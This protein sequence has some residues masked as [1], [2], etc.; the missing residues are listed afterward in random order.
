MDWCRNKLSVVQ[1]KLEETYCSYWH[2]CHYHYNPWV[3]DRLMMSGN[4]NPIW[5]LEIN[6]A[7]SLSQKLIWETNPIGLQS[8][9]SL[10]EALWCVW[11]A[12]PPSSR[13]NVPMSLGCHDS[14]AD[15]PSGKARTI[16]TTIMRATLR[17]ASALEGWTR[18][19]SS[20]LSFLFFLSFFPREVH[21]DRTLSR[22]CP[23]VGPFVHWACYLV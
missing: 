6:S 17:R 4:I 15:A 12:E 22:R 13:S 23:E 5:S 11:R 18:H 8:E 10:C 3:A 21:F 9:Q 2:L 1:A 7:D 20:S 16:S 14:V 19:P